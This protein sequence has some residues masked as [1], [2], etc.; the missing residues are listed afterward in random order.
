MDI[1]LVQHDR[2]ILSD[3]SAPQPDGLIDLS[4]GSL[5]PIPSFE[6]IVSRCYTTLKGSVAVS[7]SVSASPSVSTTVPAAVPMSPSIPATVSASRPNGKTK[8]GSADGGGGGTVL[9]GGEGQKSG[10][11][12]GREVLGMK[13]DGGKSLMCSVRVVSEVI[14]GMSGEVD[15]ALGLIVPSAT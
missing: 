15:R 5:T 10:G 6:D 2:Y 3:A 12:E 9:Q 14:R 13:L 7:V 8:S 1:N 4:C 11:R